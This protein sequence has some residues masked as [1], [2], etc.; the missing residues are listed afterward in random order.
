MI[1]VQT[2]LII[3]KMSKIYRDGSYGFI[4]QHDFFNTRVCIPAFLSY[5]QRISCTILTSLDV[6][7]NSDLGQKFSIYFLI[8]YK[9]HW[10]VCIKALSAIKQLPVEYGYL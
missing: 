2:K 7:L 10:K 1:N 9:I 6:N 8:G 3:L 5:N 4:S